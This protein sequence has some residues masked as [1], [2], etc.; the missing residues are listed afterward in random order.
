MWIAVFSVML[1]KGKIAGESLHFPVVLL[2]GHFKTTK[3][4]I[5]LCR[6]IA[7]I[8]QFLATTDGIL[9]LN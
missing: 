4:F 2:S 7:Y 6:M 5:S 3:D 9:Q 8:I 1:L